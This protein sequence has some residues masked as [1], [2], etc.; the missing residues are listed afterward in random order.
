VVVFGRLL[1]FVK[2]K[3]HEESD[4]GSDY[5]NDGNVEEH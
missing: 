4:V 3:K 2:P 1:V 5:N